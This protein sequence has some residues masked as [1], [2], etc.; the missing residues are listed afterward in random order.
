M[1][2]C[3]V[4]NCFERTGKRGKKWREN[5]HGKV[6]FHRIPE[7]KKELR[8]KSSG[9]NV[10]SMNKYSRICSCHFYPEMFDRTGSTVRLRENTVPQIHTIY[11]QTPSPLNFLILDLNNSAKSFELQQVYSENNV[12]PCSSHKNQDFP[13]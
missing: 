6:T 13:M 5:R 3:A 11:T 7:R 1:V 9:L 12:E 8:A 10:K 4:P 2:I